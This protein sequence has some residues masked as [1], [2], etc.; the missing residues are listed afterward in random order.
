MAMMV[1]TLVKGLATRLWKVSM[2]ACKVLVLETVTGTN[3]SSQA[4][5][6]TAKGLVTKNRIVGKNILV[7]GLNASRQGFHKCH[8]LLSHQVLKQLCWNR[9][10]RNRETDSGTTSW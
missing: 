10:N 8:H 5:A 3:P 7:K 1:L 6:G 9:T 2:L 4:S